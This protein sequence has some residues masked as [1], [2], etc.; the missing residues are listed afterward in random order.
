MHEPCIADSPAPKTLSL[1]FIPTYRSGQI[2]LTQYK[3]E[4]TRGVY[5]S[6]GHGYNYMANRSC[7]VVFRLGSIPVRDTVNQFKKS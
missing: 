7:D 4:V 1:H 2:A 3:G 5:R 6:W